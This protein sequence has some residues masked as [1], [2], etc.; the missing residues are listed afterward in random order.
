MLTDLRQIILKVTP[1]VGLVVFSSAIVH[2]I[3]AG[4]LLK[5]KVCA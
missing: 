1:K 3:M 5:T 2:L 4:L